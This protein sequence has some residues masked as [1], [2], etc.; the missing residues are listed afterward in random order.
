MDVGLII[1]A[2]KAAV[3]FNKRHVTLSSDVLTAARNV[4]ILMEIS[5]SF[6]HKFGAF[7]RII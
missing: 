7:E 3:V 2:A 1:N 6:T 4:N 5:T